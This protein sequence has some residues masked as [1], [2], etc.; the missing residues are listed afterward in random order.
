MFVCNVYIMWETG[1]SDTN[2]N[3]IDNDGARNDTKWTTGEAYADILHIPNLLFR[4]I[5]KE[6]RTRWIISRCIQS[7]KVDRIAISELVPSLS[8]AR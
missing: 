2:D 5:R 8:S 1:V 3:N 4:S 7:L 6:H